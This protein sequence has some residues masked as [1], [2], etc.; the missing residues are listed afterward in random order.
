M[1][2]VVVI[3]AGLGGLAA[4]VDLAR[5][6]YDVEVVEAAD[7]PGGKAG[8]VT[9]DGVE[10]D[11][12][13]SVMTLPHVLGGLLADAGT[14]LAD[15]LTLSV[16]DIV[17]RYLWP[18][19]TALDILQDPEDSADNVARVLGDRA[20]DDF[21]GFLAYSRAMWE[22]SADDFVFGPAPTPWTLWRLGLTRFYDIPKLDPLRTMWG[23]IDARCESPYLKDLFARFA[24]YNGSDVRVAPAT[25]NCIAWVELG[26]GVFGVQGGI[27]EVVRALVRVGERHGMRLRLGS[28]V[29]RIHG[30]HGVRAVELAGGVRI[31]CQ[32]VVCNADVRHLVDTLAPQAPVPLAEPSM[33]GWVG[34]LKARRSQRAPHTVLFGEPYLD[35]FRHIFDEDRPP[36][37]P[38]VYLCAQEPCHGRTGWAEHEPVFVMA[39]TPPEPLGRPRDPAIWQAL[40]ERVVG[41]LRTHGLMGPSDQLV[42][43][44]T[45]QGLAQRFPGSRGAIYGGSSNSRMAAFTRPPNRHPR[46]RGLYLA[47]G[48]AHPGGGMPLCLQSGRAAATCVVEDLG[49][50]G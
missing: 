7:Q 2:D 40:E 43:T 18:D 19:G 29:V 24:T 33:S 3:G 4:A 27:H 30:E 21:R 31:D 41:R 35:E 46:M 26:L 34:I 25:L 49:R 39:N 10:V 28:P 45:P 5:R 22:A 17:T 13:P 47:S 50:L 12:G 9:L 38:T 20:G 8:T 15:E 36:A 48:S 1:A 23:A 16:P 14:Q 42:H 44:R 32:A 37:M 11:T 6:G